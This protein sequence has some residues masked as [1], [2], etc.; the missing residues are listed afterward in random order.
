M[1][2]IDRVQ[3][4]LF[5]GWY[6]VTRY[7]P[8]SNEQK[9]S[10]WSWKDVCYTSYPKYSIYLTVW[11]LTFF[12]TQEKIKLNQH[13]F[14]ILISTKYMLHQH[15]AIIIF[16]SIIFIPDSNSSSLDKKYAS[17]QFPMIN[18][19]MYERFSGVE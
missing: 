10:R 19:K 2:D 1:F 12:V 5:Y 9:V 13:G 16:L 6:K 15:V 18:T 8:L 17:S 3:T 7:I 14:Y 4:F 11:Y